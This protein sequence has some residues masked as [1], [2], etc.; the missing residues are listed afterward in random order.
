MTTFRN[1]ICFVLEVVIHVNIVPYTV[2]QTAVKENG[3][4]VYKKCNV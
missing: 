3:Q 4:A 1:L 2:F